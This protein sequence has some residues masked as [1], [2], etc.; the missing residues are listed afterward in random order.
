[1]ETIADMIN[2][3]ITNPKDDSKKNEVTEEIKD[4]TSKFRLYDDLKI[5]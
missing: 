3:V 4:L 1:M 2:K 5:G